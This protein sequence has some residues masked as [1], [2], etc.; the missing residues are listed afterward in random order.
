M[1]ISKD[2]SDTQLNEEVKWKTDYHEGD[3]ALQT[4]ETQQK[5][6]VILNTY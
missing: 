5:Y 4:T 6:C 1:R 2:R 3:W